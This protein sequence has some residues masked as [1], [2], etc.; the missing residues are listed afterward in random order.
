[1]YAYVYIMLMYHSSVTS[2][3]PFYNLPPNHSS[4]T[5]QPQLYN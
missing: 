4:L 5:N 3:Q 2:I 1:M